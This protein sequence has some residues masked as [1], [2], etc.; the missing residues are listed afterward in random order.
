MNKDSNKRNDEDKNLDKNINRNSNPVNSKQPEI[1]PDT[2]T[3][4]S[5]RNPDSD[6]DRKGQNKD[7]YTEDQWNEMQGREQQ[8]TPKDSARN[9][10]ERFNKREQERKEGE[11]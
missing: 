11:K 7:I 2:R 5:S 9:I 10:A 4:E 8:T 3:W 1:N 6:N